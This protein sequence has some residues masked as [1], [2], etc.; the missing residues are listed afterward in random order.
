M[1]LVRRTLLLSL[2]L[3]AP[4]AAC[5]N[6]FV[7]S[8]DLNGGGFAAA[9][10]PPAPWGRSLAGN[11]L[12]GRQAE[13]SFDFGEAAERLTVALTRDPGNQPLRQRVFV[14]QLSDGRFE[15]SLR[16]ARTLAQAGAGSPL[17][18]TRLAV[19]AVRAGDFGRAK[20]LIASLEPNRYQAFLRPA[21]LAWLRL[22]DGEGPE[23]A[24]AALESLAP[25]PG[26]PA[27]YLLHKAL[28]N[29]VA[30]RVDA[31]REAFQALLDRDPTP[32]LRILQ[33][34]G[35]FFERRGNPERARQLY[36]AYRQEGA[37]SSV[38]LP[39]GQQGAPA[40]LVANAKAGFAEAIFDL[41][42]ALYEDR[43]VA[44]A[45]VYARLA[46]ALRPDDAMV[47][48]LI[49]EILEAED[50]HSEALKVYGAIDPASPFGR[51]A[52]LRMAQTLNEQDDTE[53]AVASLRALA[54][55]NA[56]DPEPLIALGHILRSRERFEEAAAAYDQAVA[57]IPELQQRHWSLLYARGIALERS[58]QW[59]RAEAD[60]KKALE[61]EPDQ[62]YVLNYL[63]YSWVDQGI[64]LAEAEKL[65]QR[66]VD[67]R[68]NDGFIV[69]S[70]GWVYYRTGNYPKAV[71]LLERAVSLEPGDP[72]LNDHLGDAYW[73]T[74]RR[75][76][77]RF[78]WSH[79]LQLNP[80]K[81][82]IAELQ[83]K[84][85]CGLGCQAKA[86]GR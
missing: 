8:A 80:D 45:L 30:G 65:V 22:A 26:F 67:L 60:L 33:L 62:P 77:A 16:N 28:L 21:G 68:P 15:D 69:D 44:I 70:L 47:A 83:A 54:A 5:G 24:L 11:Y 55:A 23:A 36:E 51:A 78:Q 35:N 12:A 53:K 17:V 7:R 39:T 34:T 56:D 52:A 6:D 74:G 43:D 76:E 48:L 59:P 81:K 25:E 84:V 86:G 41:A 20:E 2:G 4:L 73:Q 50:R 1:S 57:R 18:T 66:A 19:E 14:L 82:N 63:G 49:G 42:G 79:A 9:T 64:N 40:P 85:Q 75:T 3:L 71:E 32:S 29:D 37:R 10:T 72:V 38:L 27:L 13:R 58:N 31:A 61:F 46:Q